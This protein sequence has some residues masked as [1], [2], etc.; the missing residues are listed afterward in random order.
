MKKRSRSLS[1]RGKLALTSRDME[2]RYG[3]VESPGLLLSANDVREVI[4]TRFLADPNFTVA[5]NGTK[6]TFDDI[7]KGQL[8]E[9]D[10]DVED[11]GVA[12]LIV[13]D[14]LKADRTTR[15]HGIAW[16]VNN[17]LVG[18]PGWVGFDQE[19]LLDGRSSEAKR[20]NFI[21]RADFL[22]DAVLPDWSAFNAESRAWRATQTFGSRMHP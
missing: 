20:F 10:V 3:S 13:I 11:Y 16:V 4:G 6:V 5:I 7:P 18:S 15:Q 2:Q 21:T 8:R 17:R 22:S 1:P 19:R 9:I 12:H 14:T